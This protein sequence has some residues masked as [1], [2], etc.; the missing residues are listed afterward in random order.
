MNDT[1]RVASSTE[2]SVSLAW[3]V[4][5]SRNHEYQLARGLAAFQIAVRRRRVGQRVSTVDTQFQ[6][7]AVDPLQNIRG[8]PEQFVA[9]HYIVRQAGAR[10]VQRTLP[11]QNRRIERRHRTAGLSE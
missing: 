7:P 1:M 3:R 4:I 11:V 9:R 10:Q 6:L 2:P 5:G 8:A